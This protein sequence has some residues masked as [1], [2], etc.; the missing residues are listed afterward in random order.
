MS[1][2]KTVGATV[3]PV[4]KDVPVTPMLMNPVLLWRHPPFGLGDPWS[5][6]CQRALTDGRQ[7]V[8][9]ELSQGTGAGRPTAIAAF[10]SR[11]ALDE[12]IGNWSTTSPIPSAMRRRHA[13]VRPTGRRARGGGDPRM[14][15]FKYGRGGNRN[16]RLS[17]D[18]AS[19][20]R[21]PWP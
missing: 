12:T 1:I 18:A 15:P 21:R 19:G 5:W 9:T 7:Q 2:S 6:Y 14:R 17:L 13:F 11:A 4:A 8:P 10:V 16:G 20:P 3:M